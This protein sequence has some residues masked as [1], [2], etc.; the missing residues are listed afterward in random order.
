M[1]LAEVVLSG[2]FIQWIFN[3][4]SNHYLQ[5]CPSAYWENYIND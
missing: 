2:N 3:K 1:R 5:A 4:E